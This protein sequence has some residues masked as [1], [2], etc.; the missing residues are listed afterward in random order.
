MPRKLLTFIRQNAIALLALFVALGGTSYAALNLPAN[1]VGARQI[2][3]HTI[4]PVKL[5]PKSIA[6][7][8]RAWAIV[9]GDTAS[10]TRGP[11]SSPIRVQRI[12]TGESVTWV[13]RRFASDCIPV[14]TPRIAVDSN[15]NSVSV[16][17]R[18]NE[19]TVL[20]AGFS[21]S[22]FGQTEPAYLLIVCP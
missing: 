1:S 17:F 12:G 11:S 3:N 18:A 13:H 5:D 14:V 10:V 8:I 9:Y 21:A 2:R 6:G 16:D 7:S 22:K 19:G 15:Y 4:T 20:L